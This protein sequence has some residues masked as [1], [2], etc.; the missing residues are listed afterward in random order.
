MPTLAVGMCPRVVP[1]RAPRLLLLLA[2]AWIV[3]PAVAF[4]AELAEQRV[5]E[6]YV[7]AEDL[8][9][10][11]E[12]QPQRVLLPRDEYEDLLA[13]AQKAAETKPPRTCLWTGAEYAITLEEERARLEGVLQIESLDDALVAL[14]LDLG[15]VGLRRA[16]LDEKSAAIG[17]GPDGKWILFV[18][19]KGPHKLVLE[20]VAP[21]ETTAATQT[22][23]FRLPPSPAASIRM[24]VPGDVEVKSGLDVARREVDATAGMTRFELLP[25]AG[26]V[27]LVMTLNSHLAR[28]SR[29]VVA[30][31]V[32]IGEVT[33]A[34]EALH[35]TTSL[36]VLHQAIDQCRF[37]VPEG[38]EVTEVHSPAM[39]SWA[40]TDAPEGRVLAVKLREATTGTVVLQMM[41]VRAPARLDN[42]TMP[43]LAPLDVVGE[44]SELGL[45]VEDRLE[46]HSIRAEGPIA[47]D[48]DVLD[49]ALPESVRR[50]G[51]GRVPLRTVAAFYVPS[52]D[53][54][55]TAAFRKPPAAVSA[56]TALLL[57]LG[58]AGQA[59]RG[60]LVL[61]PEHE[62][63]FSFNL[64]VPAGWRVDRAMGAD[65]Q[66][67]TI[68]R[69]TGEDGASRVL[70]RLPRGI[71]AGGQGAVRFDASRTPP[72]WLDEW[73]SQ[74][75]E[76]PAFSIAGDVR[77]SGAIAVAVTDDLDVRPETL[78]GLVPL[79]DAQK[80]PLGLGGTAA[81]LAY[82]FDD[83]P[84]EAALTV[85]RNDPRI[86]ARTF[87]F[88]RV[89]PGA[90]VGHCEVVYR[91]EQARTR[92]LELILPVD[93]PPDVALRGADGV[94]VEYSAREVEGQRHWTV[95]L[96]DARRGDVRLLVDFLKR[97]D[98]ETSQE[99]DAPVV[100]AG[101]VAYQSGL[102]AIEGSAELDV[103]VTAKARRVDVGELVD[104]RYQPGRRLL[105]VY[106]FV[107]EPETVKLAVFHRPAYPLDP[108]VVQH[109]RLLTRLSAQGTAQTEARF[110]LATKALFL[111][112]KLPPEASLW[113]VWVDDRPVKPQ[114]EGQS[115]LVS[116]PAAPD[117]PIRRL[118]FF[119]ETPAAAVGI[120]GR[121][122]VDA[123]TLRLAADAKSEAVDVPL[124]DLQWDLY[125]PGRYDVVRSR[126]SVVT[127]D[128]ERPTPALLNVAGALWYLAGGVRTPLAWLPHG[129]A[130]TKSAMPMY[131]RDDAKIEA[132]AETAP[133]ED[134]RREDYEP[135]MTLIVPQHEHETGV[136]EPEAAEPAL[137]APAF[138]PA[139]PFAAEATVP[140]PTEAPLAPPQPAQQ[141]PAQVAG[142][143]PVVG[144]P[145]WETSK[146]S[147]WA[148][149]HRSL[150]IQ[151]A[152]ENAPTAATGEEATPVVFRSFG[153][154]P[155][156]DVTL[157]DRGRLDTFG[158]GAALVVAVVGAALTRRRIGA[159]ARYVLGVLVL[160]T[161]VPVI[162][163]FLWLAEPCNMAV[164]AAALL[165]P[166]YLL[167]GLARW[168]VC[169][170][171]GWCPIRR[172]IA[173]T[174][175]GVA[176]LS[177]ALA[178]TAATADEPA[179]PAGP[180]TVQIVPPP[181]PVA[182][183]ADAILIP[184]NPESETGIEDARRR[185]IP[186]DKYV[187]LWNR[188]YPDKKLT[189]TAPPAP[190]G[191]AGA[192]YTAR[193][194][195]TDDLLVE[196]QIELDVYVTEPVSVPL[197]LAG[198]VL[199]R[200]EEDGKPA[201]L[202]VVAPEQ[203]PVQQPAQQKAGPPTDAARPLVLWHV[204]GKGR[205]AL[206][207]AVR[208]R[209]ARQG[210]WRVA[211][212]ALPAA[213][214]T[215]LAI[216]VPA[217]QTEVRLGQLADRASYDTREADQKIETALGAEGALRIQWRPKVAEGE[218][219]RSLTVASDAA[220][221]V[222]ED[223]L[224]LAWQLA[225]SFPRGHREQFTLAVPEGYLVKR[226]EGENV[227]GWEVSPG[228]KSR[229]LAVSLLKPAADAER[230][231][232]RLW[233]AGVPAEFD[234]PVVEAPEAAL[235]KGR[236]VISRSPLLDVQTRGAR[237]AERTDLPAQQ[238]P[239]G[240]EAA[241]PLGTR[242]YQAYAFATTPFAVQLSA[243]PLAPKTTAAWQTILRIAQEERTVEARLRLGVEDRPIHRAE[244]RLP[245]G[246]T[247]ESVQAPGAFHWA[248]TDE[249]AE[250]QSRLL[251]VYF[252]QGHVGNVDIVLEGK[253]PKAPLDKPLTLP[254]WEALGVARQQGDVAVQADP[255]I[256]VQAGDLKN[257]QS[258][259]V[260]QVHAW[261][262]EPQR[263]LVQAALHHVGTDYAATLSF[264]R[265]TPDV[266]C[267][268][269]S[270]V[271]VTERAVEETILLD[272]T[273]RQA[274]V[275]KIAFLLPAW[276]ADSRVSAPLM[277]Q[278]PSIEPAA[279]GD[280][281]PVR[282]TVE[283]QDEVMDE[284][285]VLVENDRLLAAGARQAPIPIVE[286]GRTTRRYVTL[287]SAGRD[288][289]VVDPAKLAGMEPLGRKL[290]EW[291]ALRAALGGDITQ[292]Y[293]VA[294][295]AA[296]ARL[297]FQTRTREAVETAGAR[298][299]LAVT[300]LMLDAQGAYR[301]QVEYRV[302]NQTAQ[303]LQIELPHGARLWAAVVAGEPVKPIK[304]PDAADDRHVC[305]PLVKTATGDVAYPVVLVYGG[306]LPALARWGSTVDFPVVR[307]VKI[308]PE[309]SQV[310]L[311]LP[312][313]HR[314]FDFG[315]TMSRVDEE[316]EL[317]AQQV[318]FKTKEAGR[319]MD[320]MKSDNPYAQAR[321]AYNF[322]Q[323][324]LE[325]GGQTEEEMLSYSGNK[326]LQKQL[327]QQSEVFSQAQRQAQQ[328]DAAPARAAQ[329]DNR[330]ELNDFYANQRNAR[331]ANVVDSVGANWRLSEESSKPAPD[332]SKPATYQMNQTWLDAN[333]LANPAAA[334]GKEKKAGEVRGDRAAGRVIVKGSKPSPKMPAVSG[335]LESGVTSSTMVPQQ[336]GQRFIQPMDQPQAAPGG[337][338]S[339]SAEPADKVARYKSQLRQGQTGQKAYGLYDRGRGVTHDDANPLA[340][341]QRRATVGM[342]APSAFGGDPNDPS[343]SIPRRPQLA[344]TQT[345]R[346]QFGVGVQS[347]MGLYGPVVVDGQPVP[348]GMGGMGGMGGGMGMGGMAPG[349]AQGPAAPAGL[350]SLIV[351]LPEPNAAFYD[352]YLFTTPRGRIDLTARAVDDQWAGE[353]AR[354][355]L[356]VAAL[357]L[358]VMAFR[359]IGR[360]LGGWLASPAGSTALLVLGVL[361][362]ASC[363][364][365]VAGAA[366]LLAGVALK[367][368]RRRIASAAA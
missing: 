197:G 129:E 266:T 268:T 82:R 32:Q 116:L 151:L 350:A 80:A 68:E 125:L 223:G 274:G 311:Y 307:T 362:L 347:D 5:R 106:G 312:K 62:K 182:V 329:T 212:G 114:R 170:A 112:L 14:P 230:F 181:A 208:M 221:D 340:E 283:L 100:R 118:Q 252:G 356:V 269:I 133:A 198:G 272:F 139:D 167:A 19:G 217:A 273:I 345:G 71:P 308:E 305:I 17:R 70:V 294:P 242:P 137:P 237:G 140:P 8:H 253:L 16:T 185:L 360:P 132:L 57:T 247:L 319:L 65:G 322:Q 300:G 359:R 98:D 157:A 83:L 156:L 304:D 138:R 357:A 335:W 128:I 309:Q 222:R 337:V 25:R 134:A 159:R 187:E 166:Y 163:G 260:G 193:L 239:A 117:K 41:A 358:A 295:D 238:G 229:K 103:Q 261:L 130:K 278:K 325:Q 24:T 232:V 178:A 275:R 327:A 18:Q 206:A 199:A 324:A 150:K 37:L 93:T 145:V 124:V 364:F 15:G 186:Y 171:A 161:V 43:R 328:I 101:G 292:A 235:H 85:R 142:G 120:L 27:T 264:A 52:G 188:A 162:P 245:E 152:D 211:E 179:P 88:L 11:L 192:A 296:E 348:P 59:V 135:N 91:V 251:T 243:A 286:T 214:A 341:S 77:Q 277:R 256:R 30:R 218:V 210:G 302:D 109:A 207:V 105:G 258:V 58:D 4:A 23:R 233:R 250:A 202:S 78:V 148:R 301:G 74:K 40:V 56:T 353:L 84:F 306:K 76:F 26:D 165:V 203:Q 55:L 298:I 326:S 284:L 7:P 338:P 12:G 63:L 299:G 110:D 330:G 228:E 351:Q 146:A 90:L 99:L 225:L 315:G 113:S 39:A 13:K 231:T 87:S 287:E 200:A 323:L 86:T 73:K 95:K 316:A 79:D 318:A 281:A 220:L 334:P 42:W 47:I 21:L 126:G 107:G 346:L 352:A 367:I 215:A 3:L 285:R 267:S 255:S 246:F 219:D 35:A 349:G 263:R 280:N 343:R 332:D 194:E 46:T 147:A 28:T 234:A 122:G 121:V 108:A 355:V 96:A 160:G 60:A 365:P 66:A 195:G 336:Q 115:V 64:A 276:M 224:A 72:G 158:W 45:L 265:R 249:G 10:L 226:V 143:Q 204:S 149:G 313:T 33:Q 53:Y 279:A 51:E 75:I 127:N 344:G 176:L 310:R 22:L 94:E 154:D 270:N 201:R 2:L 368:R 190:F 169:W 259:L 144:K 303:F 48:V 9:V 44:T 205:H 262:D 1:F 366:L 361:G 49:A 164:Y 320:A 196:G 34:Y 290:R 291:Q 102:V 191:L 6:I 61:R 173:T 213:P 282:V 333:R 89:E 183:P 36:A 227:R 29:V 175:T 236:L 97:L 155:T 136:E 180:I 20:M 248:V 153:V 241:S 67:L 131:L 172:W 254:R 119:Y 50:G 363:I 331:A 257:C 216:T 240:E 123:P 111:E 209:L 271:R 31:G 168:L 314:W 293:L 174:A 321:A 69:F 288:E 81:P 141:Q 54:T 92:S 177:V 38:F 104:A 317:A 297:E 244:I 289:V 342:S 339:S 189:A 354:L 184:Y